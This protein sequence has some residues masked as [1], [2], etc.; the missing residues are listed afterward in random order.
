M[1]A[2]SRLLATNFDSFNP[3]EDSNHATQDYFH[4]EHAHLSASTSVCSH[5]ASS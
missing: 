1:A 3:Q 4:F 2:R 5:M